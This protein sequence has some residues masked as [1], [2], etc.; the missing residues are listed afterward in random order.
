MNFRKTFSLS[1]SLLVIIGCTGLKFSQQSLNDTRRIT[2]EATSLIK[3]SDQNYSKY[4][5][6]SEALKQEVLKIYESEKGRKMN[7]ATIAMWEEVINAKGNLFDFLNK[8]KENDKLSPAMGEQAS[9]QIERLLH[10][11]YDFE[12]H[13]KR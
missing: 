10:S 13:K 2:E 7:N 12:N 4:A 5:S 9:R 8:W 1:L 6:Q 11:I 3:K